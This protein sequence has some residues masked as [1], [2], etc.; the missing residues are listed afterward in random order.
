[1]THTT[2]TTDDERRA[3]RLVLGMVDQDDTACRAVIAE[4][5]DA[6][7]HSHLLIATARY[8]ASLTVRAVPDAGDQL[9]G[10]L[11]GMAADEGGA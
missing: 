2:I 10:V 1:M 4:A 7:R 6:G 8:A 11:L 3:L 5:V 9:R